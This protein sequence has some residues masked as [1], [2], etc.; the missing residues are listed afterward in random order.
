VRT[1]L[2]AAGNASANSSERADAIKAR[3]TTHVDAAIRA[4]RIRD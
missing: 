4:S 1:D 3:A 2:D